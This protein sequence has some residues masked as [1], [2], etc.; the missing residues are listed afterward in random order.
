MSFNWLEDCLI[1]SAHYRSRAQPA[2]RQDHG[3][4][5]DSLTSCPSQSGRSSRCPYRS[6]FCAGSGTKK[7]PA[8]TY[9]ANAFARDSLPPSGV[10]GIRPGTLDFRTEIIAGPFAL[11]HF[12]PDPRPPEGHVFYVTDHRKAAK[13]P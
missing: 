10:I 8:L 4:H 12:Q 11:P 9:G 2:Q 13:R 1:L 7:F 3:R 5:G 6:G